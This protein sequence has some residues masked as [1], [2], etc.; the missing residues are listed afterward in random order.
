MKAQDTPGLMLVE[1]TPS[2]QM[3]YRT[4]LSKAGFAPVCA[5]S[6]TEARQVF[7]QIRP[8]VVLLDM[9]LPDGDGLGLMR[10][11]LT[12]APETRVIVITANGS[13]N[14]AVE[15]T[16]KGA[17]DFLVKPL[18]D[19]RLVSTVASAMTESRARAQPKRKDAQTGDIFVANSAA[20]R[21]VQDIISA[22][23]RS[24]APVFI[25]GPSGTGKKTCANRIHALSA[26][27]AGPCV[28]VDCS[29]PDRNAL[30]AAL[31][32]GG[33]EP[34]LSEDSALRRAMGGTLV[35]REPQNLPLDLQTRLV[36]VLDRDQ[37]SLAQH[38]PK[39]PGIRIISAARQDPR[40]A[41]QSGQMQAELFY[42]L[43]VLPL[44]LPLLHERR[45]DVPLLAQ[46]FLI[47]IAQQE[48]KH[49]TRVAPEAQAH[50]QMQPWHG[51]LHEFRNALRQAI[52]LNEG[53]ELTLQ[54]LPTA[55][56]RMSDPHTGAQSVEFDLDTA[57]A[58]M[59]LAQIDARAIRA[60]IARHDGSIIKAAQEL[61]I[62][63]STIY[64]RRDE[65]SDLLS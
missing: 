57:L 36:F 6:C 28:T 35:L 49:F 12:V 61:D 65:W 5:A 9:M 7:A 8:S 17:F 47:E 52:V 54:M 14:K 10:E 39:T 26:R 3:L 4:V 55:Q 18:G 25:L 19:V 29:A 34:G 16:R 22:V 45:E 60:A 30:E 44:S 62:A 2:L 23:A 37:A 63:P 46:H 50:L 64:R 13:V 15:A 32:G 43:F 38:S 59:T 41:L 40:L 53:P 1:D 42:R 58:G 33:V 21:E 11:F 31:F 51:N 27:A 24:H 20:M 48:N 56:N